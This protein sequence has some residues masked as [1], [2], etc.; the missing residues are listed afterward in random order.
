MLSVVAI[1]NRSRGWYERGA[2]SGATA[3]ARH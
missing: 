1:V 2:K 3:S